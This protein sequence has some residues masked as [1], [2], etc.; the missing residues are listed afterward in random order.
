MLPHD[1]RRDRLRRRP[2]GK[3]HTSPLPVAARSPAR[4]AM[5]RRSCEIRRATTRGI[6]RC[7]RRGEGIRDA[8][9]RIGHNSIKNARGRKHA[10]NAGARM[11]SGPHQIQP[12]DVF[13]TI[14][15]PKPG[16]LGEGRRQSKR[17]AV[18]RQQ[19]VSKIHR[20]HH[21]RLT[22]L[23]EFGKTVRLRC[24]QSH[25]GRSRSRCASRSPCRSGT[26][27]ST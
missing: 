16:A 26:G 5:P 27:E 3:R 12:L 6:P 4:S 9:R 2:I 24:G 22:M 7:L 15:G 8:E 19:A 25:G 18:M 20:C 14:V 11:G 13:A 10:G 1:P 23:F 17:C 21:A